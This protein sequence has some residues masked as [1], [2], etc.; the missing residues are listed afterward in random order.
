MS[1][2]DWGTHRWL[3]AEALAQAGND[4]APSMGMTSSPLRT[5]FFSASVVR[6]I[7][8]SGNKREIDLP[9]LTLIST[10]LPARKA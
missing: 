4:N 5:K 3:P 6:L 9:D 8:T 2:R 1:A 7:R 10:S